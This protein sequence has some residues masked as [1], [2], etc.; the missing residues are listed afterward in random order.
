ML[1]R[2]VFPFFLRAY[3]KSKAWNGDMSIF[4]SSQST[5]WSSTSYIIDHVF[6]AF[7]CIQASGHGPLICVSILI[8]QL[9]PL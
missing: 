9:S 8:L 6:R 3:G 5:P 2:V 1:D 7:H 4:H